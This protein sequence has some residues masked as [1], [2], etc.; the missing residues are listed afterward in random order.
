[1]IFYNSTRCDH[2]NF[3]TSTFKRIAMKWKKNLA[4]VTAFL[5]FITINSWSQSG[6]PSINKKTNKKMETATIERNEAIIRDL[7]EQA[8][9]NRKTEL[10]NMYIADEFTGARGTKGG[11]G[12]IEPLKPLLAAFP[13]IRWQIEDIFADGNKVAVL[14]KWKGTHKVTFITLEPT[15]KTITNEGLAI[16]ELKDGKVIASHVQTDRLGF[17]QAME[18]LPADINQLYKMKKNGN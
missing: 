10:L 13:D 2:E 8:L 16:F 1:M 11:A 9:N 12:F 5:L 7:F 17:L 6:Q 4:A 15:G 18:A 14:W 3:G